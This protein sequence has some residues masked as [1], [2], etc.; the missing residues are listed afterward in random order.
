MSWYKVTFS[1]DEM[2]SGRHHGLCNGFSALF[3]AAGAPK[4]AG[5][6]ADADVMTNAYYFSPGAI[7]IAKPLIAIYAG[8]ECEAPSK[9]AIKSVVLRDDGG[10]IP[11]AD[12]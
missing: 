4:N 2:A 5:M 11:F 1:V 8:V 7:A 12:L 10:D 3:I 6:F 9:S